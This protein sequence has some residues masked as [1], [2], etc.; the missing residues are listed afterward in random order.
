MSSDIPTVFESQCA[1]I[2]FETGEVTNTLRLVAELV[3][4]FALPSAAGYCSLCKA[5]HQSMMMTAVW[6]SVVM[7]ADSRRTVS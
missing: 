1:A 4:R 5:S 2:F 3:R 7:L 6:L